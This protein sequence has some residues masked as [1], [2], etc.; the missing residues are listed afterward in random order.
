MT[1]EEH[2][3]TVLLEECAEVQKEIC[4]ALRF[5]LHDIN[6][7]T[8]ETNRAAITRELRDIVA[9]A[10]ILEDEEILPHPTDVNLIDRKKARVMNYLEYA[11]ST[12]AV[13]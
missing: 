3:L 11:K 2:L 9:V 5:G 13:V 4:K 8:K 1:R 7:E 10:E 12:G 6:P